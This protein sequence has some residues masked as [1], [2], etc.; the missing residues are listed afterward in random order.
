MLTIAAATKKLMRHT[1]ISCLSKQQSF[2]DIYVCGGQPVGVVIDVL[3]N[4]KYLSF[5]HGVYLDMWHE[6]MS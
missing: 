3:N 2:L 1:E 6:K 4:L 5:S